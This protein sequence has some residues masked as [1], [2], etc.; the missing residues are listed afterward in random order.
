MGFINGNLIYIIRAKYIT[1]VVLA[2]KGYSDD[3]MWLLGIALILM[4]AVGVFS[5]FVPYTGPLTNI[6]ISSFSPGEVGYVDDFVARTIDLKTFTVGE[7][8]TELL[9]AYP[10]LEMST[11]ILGG[12]R[13]EASINVPDYHLE[14]ARGISL[15]FDVAQTNQYGDLVIK[16][17]GRELIS[18]SLSAGH[19][20]I[21][22]GK[23]H[24][25]GSNTIEVS[26]MGPGMLFWASTVYIIK[27]FNINL[28]Y[29]PHRIIPFE[30]L[31]SEMDRFDRTE[32]STYAT[33]TGTLIM[34]ING[35][36]VYSASP[37]GVIREEFTL[38][39]APVKPGQNIITFIDPTGTY[40]LRDTLFKVYIIGDQ[41]MASHRFNLTAEHFH[42]LANSIFQGKVDYM[43]ERISRPGSIEIEVNG[44]QLGT[45]T[46][47]VG[48]NSA[49][50]TADMVDV[51][52]NVIVFKG[53]GSFEV[54]EAIVGL[55]R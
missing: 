12:N 38:F 42:F 14:T 13:E 28:E 6:T 23:E 32:L 29:G 34:K 55:E 37:T 18:D 33:G 41:S 51:G 39:E 44:R 3:F 26:A 2:K 7:Q 45:S 1:G 53:T 4:I 30:M 17:N 46:P 11:S 20:E 54:T 40:T 10:Q 15:S 35:V 16:W 8:Q 43:I 24:V 25:R 52:E 36:Q 5:F 47:R 19:H 22:I 50:F 49:F 27:N 9:K 31:P 48:W 21:F